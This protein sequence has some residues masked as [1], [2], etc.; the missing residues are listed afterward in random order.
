MTPATDA[1]S[2]LR[3]ILAVL[4]RER[5]AFASLDLDMIVECSERK[6]SGCD[7]L[8]SASLPEMER[9]TRELLEAARRQ[10]EINRRMRNIIANNVTGR[11]RRLTGDDGT[12]RAPDRTNSM[13]AAG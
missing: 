1:R 3:Q 10:N 13:N 9:E 12:Y 7:Q 8:S 5:Q 6:V 2:T 11:L 4:E